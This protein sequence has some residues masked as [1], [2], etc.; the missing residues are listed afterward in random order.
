[1]G[2]IQIAMTDSAIYLLPQLI[3]EDPAPWAGSADAGVAMKMSEG[4]EW[5]MHCCLT[6]AWLETETEAAIPTATLAAAFDLPAH[7]LNKFLQALT[8]A[9]ILTSSAGPRGGFKLA[10][11]PDSITL[12]DVV[13]A[14]EGESPAFRCTDIR[15]RGAGATGKPS[16]FA[17][18]C[19]IAAAMMKADKAWRSSLAGET[20][21]DL[22]GP[23]SAAGAARMRC[24]YAARG[25]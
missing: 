18:P 22:M 4:V 10:R 14:I 25:R 12:L 17:R 16:E 1:M 2:D 9:D 19:G 5:A 6:L 11:R 13:N 20:I 21:Q 23:G 3:S 15:R 24:W 7:Y 8:R